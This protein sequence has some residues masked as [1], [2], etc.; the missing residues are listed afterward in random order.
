MDRRAGGAALRRG[1][2][3]IKW[4]QPPDEGRGFLE[5]AKGKC[6]HVVQPKFLRDDGPAGDKRH[7]PIKMPV[8]PQM[9]MRV[10]ELDEGDRNRQEPHQPIWDGWRCW[11]TRMRVVEKW[12]KSRETAQ[13]NDAERAMPTP[14]KSGDREGLRRL[15]DR[16]DDVHPRC[17]P[18]LIVGRWLRG[19]PEA[20]RTVEEEIDRMPRRKKPG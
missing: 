1:A 17:M 14:S 5:K 20:R 18:E 7:M 13:A 11:R 4:E 19:D 16:L 6:L 2:D 9:R 10:T 15:L 12:E 3:L 8:T